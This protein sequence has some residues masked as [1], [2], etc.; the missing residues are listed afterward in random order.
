MGVG[1]GAG[2]N[3]GVGV[4]GVAVGAGVPVG[5]SGEEAVGVAP[6]SVGMGVGVSWAAESGVEVGEVPNAVVGV[7]P[8]TVGVSSGVAWDV[9]VRVV[10]TV[11]LGVAVGAGAGVATGR[12]DRARPG[13]GVGAKVGVGVTAEVGTSV[14]ATGAPSGVAV[15]VGPGV[16][17]D[18]AR[19]V[20][21]C[22][23]TGVGTATGR[24]EASI[25]RVRTLSG[26]RK[27]EPSSGSA[28][29]GTATGNIDASLPRTGTWVGSGVGPGAL[30][31]RTKTGNS[32]KNIP[33]LLI[34]AP[35]PPG[36][37]SIPLP[38][39]P[40]TLD[41]I[42]GNLVYRVGSYPGLSSGHTQA[43]GL[44]QRLSVNRLDPFD[45]SHIPSQG[46]GKKALMKPQAGGLVQ[47]SLHLRYGAQLSTQPN[48]PKRYHSW[49]E[50]SVPQ[51]GSH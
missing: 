18:V 1:V 50:C 37:H 22:V 27:D 14:T 17:V 23:A 28:A 30:Q 9:G 42:I 26:V 31:A 49:P 20:P 32:T 38:D 21:D 2:V 29:D 12:T 34:I 33:K 6:I 51:A 19:M 39:T 44:T 15:G 13:V 36:C 24:I 43:Q 46:P 11:N 10:K 40:A 47:P 8:I 16:A 25:P 48:F 4:T 41:V 7:A 45:F 35:Q 5:P 3:V